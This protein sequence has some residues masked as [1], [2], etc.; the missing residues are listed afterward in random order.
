MKRVFSQLIRHCS[1]AA[2]ALG[3][4][5]VC[6]ATNFAAPDTANY[7]FTTATNGTLTDMA[8]ATILLQN[9]SGGPVSNGDSAVSLIAP[10]GFDFYFMGSATPARYSEFAVNSEGVMRLGST[11][12]SINFNG[13][14][15]PLGQ[16]ND[17]PVLAAYAQNLCLSSSGGRVHYIVTGTAPNRVLTVEWRNMFSGGF[18][19]PVQCGTPDLTFQIRLYETSGVI[20][21]VYGSMTETGVPGSA[22]IGF[23]SANAI[24]QIGTVDAQD[25]GNITYNGATNTAVTNNFPLGN[26]ASLHSTAVDSR[27]VFRFT[28]PIPNAPLN[29]TFANVLATSMTLQWADNSVDEKGFAV[30]ASDD[31]GANFEFRGL[32]GENATAA[33]ITGLRSNTK[34]QFRVFAVSES[35]LS[36]PLEGAEATAAATVFSA[37]SGG[38][39]WSDPATWANAAVP[40]AENDVFI[41][42]GAT[43]VLDAAT[44]N[45]NDIVIEGIL[46]FTATNATLNAGSVSIEPSGTFRTSNTSNSH[47]LNVKGNVVNNGILNLSADSSSG[48]V[49]LLFQGNK[50]A[51]LSGAGSASD[52]HTISL[53]QL[54]TDGSPRVVEISPANFTVRNSTTSTVGFLGTLTNGTIKISGTFAGTHTTFTGDLTGR[55]VGFHLNNPNYT[56]STNTLLQF[57]SSSL[58]VSAGNLTLTN[59][60]SNNG[61]LFTTGRTLIE[62]GTVNVPSVFIAEDY[63]QTGGTVTSC[64]TGPSFF[65]CGFGASGPPYTRF[66]MSG[67]AI[68]I[69]RTGTFGNASGT[70]SVTGGTLQLGNATSPSSQI[71]TIAGLVPNLTLDNSVSGHQT[72]VDPNNNMSVL[73]T[74]EIK[75]GTTLRTGGIST[76]SSSFSQIGANFINNGTLRVTQNITN[77]APFS[78]N[79][80]I[81]QTYSGTGV[82]GTTTTPLSD[83]GIFNPAGV[84]IDPAATTIIT[85]RVNLFTGTL[86][87]SNKVQIRSTGSLS[88]II[89]R[90][91]A[92][93]QTQPPGEFDVPPSFVIGTT[94]LEILY[95]NAGDNIETGNEIPASRTVRRVLFSCPEGITIAG[96]DLTIANGSPAGAVQFTSGIVNTGANTLFLAANTT[97]ARTD[98]FVDGNLRINYSSTGSK[99]FHVGTANGYSPVTASV[100]ALGVNPSSLTISAEQSA[101]PNAANAA[102]ALKRFWSLTETGDL[103]ATLTFGYLEADLPVGLPENSL[104][105]KRYTGA[106]TV[107]DTIPATL[108]T[109]ANTVTTTDAISEFSDWTLLS[110]LAPTSANVSVGGRVLSNGRGVAFATVAA[111]DSEGTTR[112][113]LSN[114]LGFFRIEDVPAG[115]NYVIF[116][117]HK[118]LQ[119]ASRVIFATEDIFDLQFDAESDEK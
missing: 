78:F 48:G 7:T 55:K 30:Y 43:V 21:Y 54:G 38:G 102:A 25:A 19:N 91:N 28:P 99:V 8:G 103:A 12:P 56:V 72:L 77:A 62:G 87:N 35:G 6:T 117:R 60:S 64:K 112:T 9:G 32:V 65:G 37:N 26:I 84:T 53:N 67:G 106:G 31:G 15:A 68:V 81:P 69:E 20:E 3:L 115:E 119:F 39:N 36:D 80:N 14:T 90:G 92:N 45:A 49:N 101:H 75:S 27:R 59:V 74:T 118:R 70:R 83:F 114:H 97:I 105:L 1:A 89:Q 71:F 108:N 34:Y 40:T 116:V 86:T 5:F 88:A 95:A 57:V 79:S 46:E 11:D 76:G 24:G 58:T 85:N 23:S 96:G 10:I 107:F 61:I 47:T 73:G 13:M 44:Q 52:I 2:L 41:P 18:G 17:L 22:Q 111:T 63:T 110:S 109:T 104:E 29:L 66:A 113:A 33:N 51:S 4:L 42:G 82:A 50:D 93:A 98:G 94:G 16:S 100:S